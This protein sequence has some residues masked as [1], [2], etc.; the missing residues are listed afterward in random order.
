MPYLLDVNVL[1]ALLDAN[2]VH[3]D[4]AMSWFHA[5]P[6]NDWLSCPTTQNGTIRVMSGSRYSPTAFS[7]AAVAERLQLLMDETVHRFIAD[8][9]SLLDAGRLDQ[10][11]LR[12]RSQITDAYLL[13]LAV[14]NGA[15]LATMDDRLSASL[16]TDGNDHLHRI[17]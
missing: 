8:D 14:S 4:R 2:H 9:I 10:N 17:P 7:P 6:Q 11:G 5:G 1:I 15:H 3:H 16:V 12:R 13:A